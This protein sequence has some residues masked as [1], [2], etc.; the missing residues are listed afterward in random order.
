M[1]TTNLRTRYIIHKGEHGLFVSYSTID[2]VR[3]NSSGPVSQPRGTRELSI[4]HPASVQ[5]AELARS[6]G[7]V[8]VRLGTRNYCSVCRRNKEFPLG[9][10]GVGGTHTT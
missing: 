4:L 2:T 9:E 3:S 5:N 6:W 10:E 7:C 1:I 8:S